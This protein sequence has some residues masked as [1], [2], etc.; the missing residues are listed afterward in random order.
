M[1]IFAYVCLLAAMLACVL[2]AA[3]AAW[4]AWRGQ[5]AAVTVMERGQLVITGLT[6]V[7][8]IVLLIFLVQ[9]N[10]SINYVADYTDTLLPMFYRV[11]AFWAGQ[12]GSLLFWLWVM[13]LFGCFFLLSPSYRT[14]SEETKRWHWI[15]FLTLQAF[16]LLLLT[17]WS[18]PFLQTLPAPADGRGLNPLLQHPGMIFHPPLLFLGYAGF[19]IP[20]CLG[21]AQRLAGDP[22]AKG[23]L[24]IHAS[25]NVTLLAWLFLTSGIILGGWWSYM[26]LGWGGY[27]AWDPVENASLIPWFAGTAFLHTGVLARRRGALPRTNVFLASLALF[28]SIFATYLVRSGVIDSLHAFG[29]GGVGTPLMLFILGGLALTSVA[30]FGPKGEGAPLAGPTSREGLLFMTTWLLLILGAVIIV[31]TMWPVIS[32]LWSE[33]PEGLTQGFY[34]R[35]CLPFFV[36]IG[37]FLTVCPF[38]GW[39]GG[40]ARPR[41]LAGVAGVFVGAAVLLG[42]TGVTIPLALI[43]AAAGVAIVAGA[44]LLLATDTTVRKRLTAWSAYGVHLS[45]GLMF[46]GVAFSGPYKMEEE[47]F[48]GKGESVIIKGYEFTLQ[49]LTQGERPNMI[50]LRGDIL[51]TREGETIGMLHP[52][53]RAYHKFRQPFAE[54]STI[55]SLGDEVYASLLGLNQ[56]G[57]ASV[58]LSVHPLVNWIWIGGALM[59]LFPFLGLKRFKPAAERKAKD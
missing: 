38:V 3:H 52:E 41:A 13:A 47:V 27:W 16:F 54:A 57:E 20:G 33:N 45:L 39:K 5:A 30:A 19:A 48:L 15:L 59:C 32:N 53:R 37:L 6:T 21:L 43:G 9:Q 22:A 12:A 34:N 10:Y 55:F 42:T 36:L 24:W 25:R 23:M 4:A 58:R 56:Q 40:V 51:V 18:N 17:A 50:Y 29:D 31:G 26:E 46:L 2:L 8:S 28:M 49:E 1:H 11:T 14:L 44:I 7:S 35:V